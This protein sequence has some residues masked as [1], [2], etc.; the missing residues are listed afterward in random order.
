MRSDYLQV[1]ISVKFCDH[2]DPG[3]NPHGYYAFD[4]SMDTGRG[5]CQRCRFRLIGWG[6]GEDC[7]A[8]GFI[9]DDDDGDDYDYWTNY[10]PEINYSGLN[11]LFFVD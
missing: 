2:C 10:E 6:H 9:Q 5:Q 1:R 7:D 11:Q 3:F 4:K 8:C